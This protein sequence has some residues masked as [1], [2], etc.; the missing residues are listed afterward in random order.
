MAVQYQAPTDD[1]AFV[2]RHVIDSQKISQLPGFEEFTDDVIDAVLEEAGKFNAGVISPLNTVSDET[3]ASLGEGNVV[4]T[5]PGFKEAYQQY[6]EAGWNGLSCSPDFG[7]Q[8]LP[9]L[10]AT[11]TNEMLHSASMSFGLC[12]MLTAGAIHAIDHHGSDQQKE[13][14]LP[15]LVSGE[16]AGTMNLTE[17]QAGSD[18]AAVTSKA[19]PNGDHYLISGIKIYITYG[20]HDLTENIIHLVLA[21][22]P[23]APAGVKGIS[24]FI[25]PKFLVNADGSLGARNDVKCISLEHKLG[26]HGSPTAVMSYG[27]AGGAVGYLVGKPNE[28]LAYMFTMM[29]H[30]RLNVGLQGV[31]IAERALQQAIWYAYDRVQGKTLIAGDQGSSPAPIAYHPDVRRML[32]SMQ[33]RVQAMRALAYEA[34]AH[35]DIAAASQ[36]TDVATTAQ[37]KVDVLIPVVKGWCT[38]QSQDIASLGIQIHGGM[39]YVEE[40]G[41]AQHLRD[42]RITTIYEGTTAIQA[43]DFIGRKILRDEGKG[44]CALIHEVVQTATVLTN[45]DDE[46]LARLGQQLQQGAQ[47]LRDCVNWVLTH[48]KTDAAA[49]YFG[50]VPMLMLAGDVFGGWMMAR[51]AVASTKPELA[52][53]PIAD[54][55]RQA[56]ALYGDLVLVPGLGRAHQVTAGQAAVKSALAM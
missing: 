19:V 35:M 31:A 47:T 51:A 8:G 27:E 38:E 28:G 44:V 1:M 15:K 7:G 42:A 22:L 46:A 32:A 24:L 56:A 49:V 36:D 33:C 9:E 14:Y 18:L 50:S 13:T 12:P 48:G 23:D 21:R 41:A 34:A 30:A 55:K 52:H 17:P 39:G 43:N 20:E 40:T 25:V 5:S 11:A 29:N 6:I 53:D 26:I 4:T 16:W 2:I 3:G 45:S 54:K 10:L 37:S